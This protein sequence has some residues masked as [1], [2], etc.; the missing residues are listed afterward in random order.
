MKGV[1]TVITTVIMV[2]L[3]I[4]LVGTY[5]YSL[6]AQLDF[7]EKSVKIPANGVACTGTTATLELRN[8]GD[9]PINNS[10]VY[11]V[12]GRFDDSSGPFAKWSFDGDSNVSI[13]SSGNGYHGSL[14]GDTLLLMH[15]DEGTGSPLDSTSNT[16]HGDI[17]GHEPEWQPSNLCKSG[18]CMKFDGVDDY[19]D[20]SSDTS[21]NVGSHD[22]S[23]SA[24]VRTDEIGDNEILMKGAGGAGQKRYLLRINNNPI[25]EIDDDAVGLRRTTGASVANDGEWHFIVGV[26]YGNS[27]RIYFDGIEDSAPTDITGIGNIDDNEPLTIGAANS[28]DAQATGNF[29]KGLIDEVAIYNRSLTPE[30]VKAQY[31]TG[32]ARFIERVPGK[33]GYALNA[34]DRYDYVQVPNLGTVLPNNEITVALWVKVP[35]IKARTAF[36]MYPDNPNNRFNFHPYYGIAS[37]NTYWDFGDITTTGRLEYDTDTGNIG[38]WQHFTLVSSQSNNF[39]AVYRN[40]VQEAFA[41]HHDTFANGARDLMIGGKIADFDGLIDELVIWDRAFDGSDILGLFEPSCLCSG[42]TCQCG[43]LTIM[44]TLG[45]GEFQP[46]FDSGEIPAD[47][48][49]TMTDYNCLSST[50]GYRVISPSGSQEAFADCR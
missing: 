50:C 20:S 38:T 8:L 43:E 16:N 9:S 33:V 13:D 31:D 29:F 47:G 23:I 6:S 18:R 27:L 14:H 5:Y 22:F 37:S 25:V 17:T 40:G 28:Q 48:S 32:R 12:S 44:K 26:R 1:S 10:Q 35:A 30:E 42:Q 46:F 36:R 4:A 3:I 41:N 34:I 7:L 49:V 21:L 19:I 2:A 11:A 24:W 45:D 39:M 15:L